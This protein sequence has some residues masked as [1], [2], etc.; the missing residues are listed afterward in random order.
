MRRR[1]NEI[2]PADYLL[3]M[4]VWERYRPVAEDVTYLIYAFIGWD[5]DHITTDYT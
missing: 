3:P 2:V 4:V 5:H 1:H